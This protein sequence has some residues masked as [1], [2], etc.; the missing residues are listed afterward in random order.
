MSGTEPLSTPFGS[1]LLQRFPLRKRETLR[2]WDA[3]DEYLLNHLAEEG[4]D[5]GARILILNDNFGALSVSLAHLAP[6]MQTDSFIS[7]WSVRENLKDNGLS[8][9]SVVIQDS[10]AP[11]LTSYDLVLIRV[12]K[13]LALLEDQLLCLK[14]YLHQGSRVI[15][16]GM[17]K[18]IRSSHLDLFES[19]VGP[20]TTSQAKKKARLVFPKPDLSIPPRTSP[21]P[22]CYA[23]EGSVFRLCN[24]ANVF[25]RESLDIGTRL[26][27]DHI[28]ASTEFR[29]II[30]LGCGN[31]VVGL[32]AAEAN[33]DARIWFTDES[34]MAVA[35]AELN[36]QQS[37][38]ENAAEFISGDCLTGFKPASAD[39]VLCNPPFHQQQVVGDFIAW[40][41][42]QQSFKV[43][44]D[45]GELRVIGNRHL[46]YHAKLKR[47]FGNAQVV[48][49]NPKFVVLKS[50]KA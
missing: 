45:G 3:A 25:S 30:D 44:R 22:C 6:Q 10:L 12:T 37:G 8:G 47:L 9:E 13:T 33:P 36:F 7:A 1:F 17:V 4:I 48:A 15:G 31:G 23:L 41:M 21:Y 42:F 11:H 14:S 34:Y 46:S 5:D 50:V 26:F 35:S 24:Y 49:S 32:L 28:P 27:L 2:A 29:D 38:L 39:L 19:I 40:R 16:C 18:Q 20:T 43:L